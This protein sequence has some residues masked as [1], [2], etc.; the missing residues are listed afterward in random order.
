MTNKDFDAFVARQMPKKESKVDWTKQREEWLG[1]LSNFYQQVE[2]FLDDYVKNGHISI[3]SGV[4]SIIEEGIG[5]Y[6]VKTATIKI[7]TSE[8]KL[9]PIGTN[10]IGA[11][12]RVDMNG[13]NG[14]V[15]FVL[16]DQDASEPKISVQIWAEGEKP[17]QPAKL[18]EVKLAWK[19]STPPPYIKYMELNSESFRE[20]I[21]AVANG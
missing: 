7:G 20:S 13:S 17:Q 2:E 4:K 5:E 3:N 19:I 12:G 15:R 1:Y 11:K 6:E 18:K 9:E 21:M 10:V 14:T 8:I 16:V